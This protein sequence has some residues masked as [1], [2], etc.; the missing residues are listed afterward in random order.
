MSKIEKV[1]EKCG[2]AMIAILITEVFIL[3]SAY[4]IK[5]IIRAFQ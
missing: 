3:A 4:I 2:T 5:G 1:M